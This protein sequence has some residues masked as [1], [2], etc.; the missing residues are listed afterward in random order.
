MIIIGAGISGLAAARQLDAAGIDW[1][2]LESMD[3]VGGRIRTDTVSGALID[4]GFQ[5]LNNGYPALQDCVDISALHLAAF[6][7]GARIISGGQIL[8]FQDPRRRPLSALAG[9]GRNPARPSDF[10]ALARLSV[11]NAGSE[12][13]L[14]EL[15][16]LQALAKLGFSEGFIGDFI[17]P[18]FRAVFLNSALDIEWRHMRELLLMFSRGQACLPATGMQALPRWMARKL[19]AGRIHCG[20]SVDR[21]TTGQIG[22]SDGSTADCR[23]TILAVPP[24]AAGLLLGRDDLPEMMGVRSLHFAADEGPARDALLHLPGRRES[25]PV[26][27]LA[28]P[29]NL[30]AAYK[31]GTRQ[32][33]LASSLD[34]QTPVSELEQAVRGQLA[35]WFGNAVQDWEL[36]HVNEVTEALPRPSAQDSLPANE[37]LLADRQLLL[38]GD[39]PGTPSINR[40]LESGT[41]AGKMAALHLCRNEAS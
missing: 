7:P 32:Q 27:N 25:G 30:H 12:P 9:M 28:I 26:C 31:F 3:Q 40:A 6:H 24:R 18:F 17:A 35:G 36:M 21:I 16:C 29:G 4:R 34:M 19:D 5:V 2:L 14:L 39:Y 22:L 23:L 15:P 1:L 37:S 8:S 20:H 10:A 38:C 13:R 11:A 41:A 33:V